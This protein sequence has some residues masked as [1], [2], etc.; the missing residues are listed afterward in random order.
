MPRQR[1]DATGERERES[2]NDSISGTKS[3]MGRERIKE[4]RRRIRSGKIGGEGGAGR[5]WVAWRLGPGPLTPGSK[6]E[7]IK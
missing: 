6:I 1:R 5:P 4:G 3:G 2:P 7:V